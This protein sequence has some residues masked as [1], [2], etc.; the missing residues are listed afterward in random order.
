MV[1]VILTRVLPWI[2]GLL[3][4]AT[5]TP[6]GKQAIS[7][8]AKIVEKVAKTVGIKVGK[9]T[10]TSEGI[11]AGLTTIASSAQGSVAIGIASSLIVDTLLDYGITVENAED[12][13]S[14]GEFDSEL[15]RKLVKEIRVARKE[16]RDTYLGDGDE[17]TI[18]GANSDEVAKIAAGAEESVRL[19]KAGVSAAGG[20][21]SLIAIR[22]AILMEDDA[23]AL[24]R[25]I[26]KTL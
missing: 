22:Q 4:K 16:Q 5:K 7:A 14:I 23:I 8:V 17:D 9:V 1:P 2:G 26:I 20:E 18:F 21:R 25:R 6:A 19:W 10:P 3:A 13:L 24:A 11:M 15:V 12:I